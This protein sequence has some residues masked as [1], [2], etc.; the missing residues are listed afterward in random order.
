VEARRLIRCNEVV[1]RTGLSRATVYRLV[2]SGE[3]PSP[4]PLTRSTAAWIESEVQDWID[5]R[6]AAARGP[7]AVGQD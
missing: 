6:I 5:E 7:R 1:D 2:R 4:I 3:F